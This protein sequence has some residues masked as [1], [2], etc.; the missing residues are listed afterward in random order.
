MTMVNSGLKG[1]NY[2]SLD[3]WSCYNSIDVMNRVNC[4]CVV[5]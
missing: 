2:N 5:P 4:I 3:S 1:L